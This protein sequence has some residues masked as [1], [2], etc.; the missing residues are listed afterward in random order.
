MFSSLEPCAI[1]MTFTPARPSAPNTRAATPGVPRMPSPTAATIATG[2]SML[3][4]STSWRRSSALNIR[5]SAGR[6]RSAP[7]AGTTRQ[8]EFSLEDWLIMSTFTRSAAGVSKTRAAKPGTPPMP[9]PR[10]VS[11][12]RAPSDVVALT[13][14]P[15]HTRAPG[16]RVGVD[17]QHVGVDRGGEHRRRVIGAAAPER[18]RHALRCGGDI[19]GDHGRYS[20]LEQRKEVL[21]HPHLGVVE[22]RI[23]V[24]ERIVGD[25]Q[26]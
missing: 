18:G 4:R 5:S 17:E 16:V 24:A 13:T 1:A 10:T 25:E 9:A 6:R 8:I 14:P 11:R 20:V 21:V 26:A 3:T 22:E 2:T 23:G 15:S 19:P 12:P 7:S